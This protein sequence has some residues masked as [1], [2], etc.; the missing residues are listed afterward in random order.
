MITGLNDILSLIVLGMMIVGI[1]FTLLR[2]LSLSKIQ[3]HMDEEIE[4]YKE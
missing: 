1:F 4:Y 3:S 2:S